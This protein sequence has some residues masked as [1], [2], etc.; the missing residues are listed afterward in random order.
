MTVSDMAE[1]LGVV[2][3]TVR[4]I[5]KDYAKQSSLRFKNGNVYRS[6]KG[7]QR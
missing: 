6:K 5:I 3:K 1:R 4:R 2:D 7:I